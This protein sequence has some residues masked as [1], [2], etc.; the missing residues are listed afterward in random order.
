MVTIHVPTSRCP[1][2]DHELDAA[3]G[4]TQDAVP[5]QGDFVVCIKCA[6]I[7]KFSDTM[8]ITKLNPAELLIICIQDPDYHRD[9][10]KL[11]NVIREAKASYEWW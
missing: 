4:M 11:Q 6:E 5:K 10:V 1:H 3:S 9:L 8:K 2:C 7:L